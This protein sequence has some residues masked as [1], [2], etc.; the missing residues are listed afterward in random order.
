MYIINQDND[1]TKLYNDDS[2]SG[3]G[4]QRGWLLL[5]KEAS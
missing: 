1:E 3:G 4:A 2:K 5:A